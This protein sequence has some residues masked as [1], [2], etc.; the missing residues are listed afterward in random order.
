LTVDLE[1]ALRR[2]RPSGPPAELRGR[3]LGP[4]IVGRHRH[5]W[6]LADWIY[7]LAAA[8]AAM[9]LYALT[10]STHRRVI[11]ATSPPTTEREAAIA[12]TAVSL[13][14]DERARLEA[15]RLI[16]AIEAAG[17]DAQARGTG[18]IEESIP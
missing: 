15:E 7:P 4:D 8:A 1:E 16:S 18:A 3:V 2:Y 17:V 14:G 10:D 12:E 11:A 5:G 9:I 6:R 13:G